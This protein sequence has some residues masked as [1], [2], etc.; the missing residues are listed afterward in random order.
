MKCMLVNRVHHF[1]LSWIYE[2]PGGCL[3]W[4]KKP[5]YNEVSYQC[6]SWFQYILLTDCLLLSIWFCLKLRWMSNDHK[7][8]YFGKN[9]MHCGVPLF[10]WDTPLFDVYIY[11]FCSFQETYIIFIWCMCIYLYIYVY[12]LCLFVY[13]FANLSIFQDIWEG[14]VDGLA[15][16]RNSWHWWVSALFQV[17][18]SYL[19][20][21]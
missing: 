21:K 11:M 16:A 8:I 15:N 4:F 2:V 7:N 20:H 18:A 12:Y 1:W 9:Q 14:G 6:G 3:P 5:S 13:I 19:T 10:Y 17:K